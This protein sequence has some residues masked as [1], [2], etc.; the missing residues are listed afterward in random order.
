MLIWSDNKKLPQ[1][2]HDEL[3]NRIHENYK[4]KEEFFSS[5]HESGEIFADIIVPYYGNLIEEIMKDLGLWSRTQYEYNLWVQMYNSETTTHDIHEHFTGREIISF[6]HIIDASNNKCFYFLNDNG[7]KIYPEHQDSGDIFAWSPW[8]VHGVDKVKE[9]NTTRLIVAG[10]VWL[11]RYDAPNART[12]TCS[13]NINN[14]HEDVIWNVTY[15]R[16]QNDIVKRDLFSVPVFELKVDLDKLILPSA[17]VA[18]IPDTTLQYLSSLVSSALNTLQDK[19]DTLEFDMIWRNNYKTKSD[20]QGYHIHAKTHWS[21]II[22]E[23]VECSRTVFCNPS[24]KEVQNQSLYES[25]LDMPLTYHAD[26]FKSGDM[27]LFPS[28]LAHH[29]PAGNLGTTI[30]GNIIL[31]SNN[32]KTSGAKYCQ[33]Y[34]NQDSHYM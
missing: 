10:N 28:W 3:I 7:D 9:P 8:L 21:F 1:S 13:G 5:Y 15:K 6:N 30:S 19:F 24:H 22:Y 14:D 20:Y 33:T 2:L 26:Y 32:Q 17:E 4:N 29:V 23:S 25:S 18:P 11:N 34:S 31:K 12:L 27:I 16:E